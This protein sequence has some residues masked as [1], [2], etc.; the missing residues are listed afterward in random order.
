[1]APPGTPPDPTPPDYGVPAQVVA[2]I[3]AAGFDR[4]SLASNHVMDKGAAGIDATLA[5]FDAAGLGHAGMARTPEEAG[6]Q[7]FDVNGDHVAHL[8]YTFSYNGMPVTNGEPWRSNLIDPDRIVA[9]AQR[10]ARARRQV[11]DPLG[12]LGRR[13][14]HRGDRRPAALGRADHGQRCRRRDRRPPCPR[15]ATDRAGQ[16]PL[17]R[18]RARQLPQRDE[19]VDGLLRDPRP[20]RNAGPSRRSPSSPTA[21]SPSLR[22]R[23]SRRTS[24]ATTT[25]SSQCRAALAD[26]VLAAGVGVPAL[27]ES[28]ARTSGVVG[29]YVTG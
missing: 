23:P 13:R 11:R 27:D 17:G 19:R 3:A 1:M 29:S 16:R 21:R 5:T 10:R 15:R 24:T 6:P 8:S 7:L 4:C 25:S 20:G 12:P 18:V 2:G 9:E 26:P 14:R 22:H 28:L